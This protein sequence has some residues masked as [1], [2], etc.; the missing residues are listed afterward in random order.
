M[1]LHPLAEGFAGVAGAYERGR[2]EY[3]PAVVGAIVADLGLPTGAPVLDLAAGTGKLTRALLDA[4]LEVVAVEPQDSLREILVASVGRQRVHAGVAEAIPL[5]ENSVAAV[6]VADAFHWFDQPAALTEIKRVLRARG[7]LAVL[8][9]VPDWSGASWAHEVG[10]L[11]A[12]LR[13]GHPQDEGPRWLDHLRAAEEW[14]EPRELR[15]TV[16]QPTDPER[17]ADYVGSISWIAALPAGERAETLA[18]VRALI[19]AGEMPPQLPLHVIVHL[20]TLE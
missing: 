7:A 13:T 16:A 18:R 6:F 19:G 10:T 17:V 8:S 1:A 15:I 2:P 20:A 14:T 4:G 12:S 3:P 11:L 9:T 5:T